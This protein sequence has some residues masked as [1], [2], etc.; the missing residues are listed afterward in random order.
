MFS[1]LPSSVLQ[2]GAIFMSIM[3][4]ALP[5]VLLGSLISGAIEVYVTPDRV[6]HYLPK[7]RFL[8]ILF[9]TFI[10]FFF[11]SCECGIVPIVNRFLEKKVPAYTAIPFLATAPVINPIVLLATFTA[12]GNSW[13]FTLLRALGAILV[14]LTLGILLGFVKHDSIM[15]PDRKTI[16]EHDFSQ[17]HGWR[18]IF[19]SLIQAIDEFFN[20][21]RYLVFGCLFASI[22]QVYV[23]TRVLLSISTNPLMGILL[24]MLLAF[25]L[26]LCS[27][28]DAFIA[29]SLL[30][31]F[32][33]APVMAFLVIGPIVDVKNLIMMTSYFKT[34]AIAQFIG[35]SSLVVIL[36]TLMIG[37]L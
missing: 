34:K 3:I 16:H 5:F 17:L 32:G 11:P 8:R 6:H 20:T 26:S 25:L 29:A 18:K 30:S 1:N 24:M 27:E 22:V 23:P 10:G 14:A 21:G 31:S 28:A 36:Y 33:M 37:V 19:Q 12:F 7:N 35:I 4:E 13:R 9:G 15:R 2:T